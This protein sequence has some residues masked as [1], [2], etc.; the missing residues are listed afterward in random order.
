MKLLGAR[1]DY[2]TLAY[3]VQLRPSF[4]QELKRC[5]DIAQKHSRA[6]FWWELM[7][8]D[9]E[10]GDAA[11]QIDVGGVK[12]SA[13]RLGPV[14]ARWANDFDRKKNVQKLWGELR[15][16]AQR[17]VYRIDNDPFFRM[18]V[19]EKAEGGGALRTCSPCRGTGFVEEQNLFCP[20]LR[21]ERCKLCGGKGLYEEPGFTLEFVWRAQELARVGLE[22]CV[23]ESDAIAAMCGRVFQS[24]LRRLD[25]CC[26]VMGWQVREKDL[27]NLDKRPRQTWTEFPA[28]DVGQDNEG[29]ES[30]KDAK[31]RAREAKTERRA[32]GRGAMHRRRITG[33]SIGAGGDLQSRIYDKRSELELDTIGARREKEEA[34]W[35]AAG[36]NGTA[37]VT[38]VEFQM[39]GD[40]LKQFGVRELD[41]CLEPVYE[42][43]P[44][45]AYASERPELAKRA[46]TKPA[47][48]LVGHRIVTVKGADGVER[49]ASL[50]DRIDAIWAYCLNWIRIVVPRKSKNGNAVCASRLADDRRW[51]MLREAKFFE[52]A[53][54][55]AV[56]YRP[57]KVASAAQALGVSLSMA[58]AEGRIRE[59]LPED[60][61][62]YK[63]DPNAEARLLSRVLALKTV[64]ARNIVRWLI[65]RYGNVAEACEHFAVRSN[66][67]RARWFAGVD[68]R[69]PQVARPPPLEP[70]LFTPATEVA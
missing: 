56:R 62:A 33:I 66:S 68:G 58:G 23:E 43:V 9:H 46:R 49:Q 35:R 7:V 57:R 47:R 42:R 1:V 6:A 60:A 2:L 17:G 40:V 51:A 28:N 44:P 30:P 69:G 26:D 27:W 37:P 22:I 3:R 41:T 20:V 5:Q 64:E 11:G 45:D 12:M 34:R 67:A 21:S 50:V 29:W 24:R 32:Y 61:S 48:K 54:E 63:Y 52:K 15:Y 59:H 55:P 38:R 70:S 19:K 16:S 65:D 25:L 14:R 39:R 36:W 4:V 18:Q 31:R 10:L 53:R 8:P 13:Q